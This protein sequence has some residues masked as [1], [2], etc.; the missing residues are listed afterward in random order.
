MGEDRKRIILRWKP[1]K[2]IAWP[3]ARRGSPRLRR[4]AVGASQ[5]RTTEGASNAESVARDVLAPTA[6]GGGRWHLAGPLGKVSRET[7]GG[8]HPVVAPWLGNF[9]RL[10][11]RYD[12]KSKMFLAFL[13]VACLVITLREF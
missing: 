10:V 2:D 5:R 7:R 6:G 11:V 3:Q 8:R 13:K 9:R 4:H 12:R 1:S